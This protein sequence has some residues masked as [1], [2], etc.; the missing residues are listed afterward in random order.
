MALK[1][2]ANILHRVGGKCPTGAKSH[3]HTAVILAA[4]CGSRMGADQT[5]QMML[6]DGIPLI[7]H[8]LKAFQD[9]PYIR[10]IIVVAR[11]EEID[12]YAD[13]QCDYALSKITQVVE[14]GKERAE[15]SW[16][17]V[18][19]ANPK[20][21]Y[22]SI[23]DGARCLIT[24]AMIE[25]V[26]RASYEKQGVCAA[27]TKAK[28]TIKVTNADA[29]VTQTPNRALS[30]QVQTPQTMRMEQYYAAAHACKKD[31]V[32]V[33]DDCMM[34]EHI[35]FPVRLVDCGEE[36]FKVTTKQDLMFA[37]LILQKRKGSEV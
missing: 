4:G 33:T 2:I 3:F 18:S 9:S 10:E 7:V 34:A 35:G 5:K 15:S 22:I 37:E 11:K 13:F 8:T 29:Y 24:P 20:T 28:D 23:H 32:A 26:I 31:G 14:G 27:A 21:E 25:K 19:A 6:L 36:N 17:G 30:W 16:I 12:L 1:T